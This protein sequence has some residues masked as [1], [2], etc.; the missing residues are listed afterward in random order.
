VYVQKD[1]S[2]QEL[3]NDVCEQLDLVEKDYF[4]L[5]YVDIEKQRVS[6]QSLC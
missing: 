6:L 5:R 2:G 3:M 1:T 4:G